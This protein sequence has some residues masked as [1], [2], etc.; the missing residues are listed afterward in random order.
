MLCWRYCSQESQQKQP[1]R[2]P[3]NRVQSH[4]GS[5]V[6]DEP[7][8]IILGSVEWQVPWIHSHIQRNSY[9]L[10]QSWGNSGHATLEDP[11]RP[12]MSIRQTS[13]YPKIHRKSLGPLPTVYTVNEKRRLL[14]IG[15][16]LPKGFWRYQRISY[17]A[18]S[19]SGLCFVKTIH[20]LCASYRPLWALFLHRRAMKAANRPSTTWVEL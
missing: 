7:D 3:E 18:S 12:Q 2:R 8:Q 9:W 19:P 17:Q 13:L 5:P 14:R 10:R 4:S 15:W 6:Q 11:Q 16:S 20:A 1:S